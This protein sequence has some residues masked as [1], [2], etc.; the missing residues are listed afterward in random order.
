MLLPFQDYNE[1]LQLEKL[2]DFVSDIK[3]TLRQEFSDL[4]ANEGKFPPQDDSETAIL[5]Q[6]PASL[7]YLQIFGCFHSVDTVEINKTEKSFSNLAASQF[8]FSRSNK[9]T[10]TLQF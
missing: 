10:T 9:S 4:F 8:C 5:N 6:Q 1:D 7:R 3:S 2:E